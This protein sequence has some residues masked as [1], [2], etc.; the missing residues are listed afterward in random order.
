MEASWTKLVDYTEFEE[1]IERSYSFSFGPS[2]ASDPVKTSKAQRNALDSIGDYWVSL[3]WVGTRA[4]VEAFVFI[5][6]IE[7]SVHAREKLDC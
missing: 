7:Q 1:F 2:R 5:Q 4:D 3:N 6:G